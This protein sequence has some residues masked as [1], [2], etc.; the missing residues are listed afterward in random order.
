MP[1]LAQVKPV[2][3]KQ[4]GH[5]GINT[6]VAI[7]ATT[8][9]TIMNIIMNTTTTRLQLFLLNFVQLDK[10]SELLPVRQS[11]Q[12]HSVW[13]HLNRSFYRPDTLTASHPRA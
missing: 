6:T 12:R 7:T 2:T 10:F 8:T 4:R 11:S 5:Y 13:N 1:R 9:T 3:I